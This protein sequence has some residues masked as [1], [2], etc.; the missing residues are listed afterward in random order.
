MRIAQACICE[1]RADPSRR[2]LLNVGIG[3]TIIIDDINIAV[4]IYRKPKWC[5]QSRVG[6][7]EPTPPGVNFRTLLPF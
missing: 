5:I 4:A 1:V 3:S 2:K 6:K 7:I